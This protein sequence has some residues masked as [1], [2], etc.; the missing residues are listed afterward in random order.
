LPTGEAV[1]AEGGEFGS[2]SAGLS[3]FLARRL[4]AA[5]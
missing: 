2:E 3:A 5:L 4:A 1:L